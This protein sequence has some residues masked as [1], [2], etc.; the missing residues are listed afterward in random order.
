MRRS[1]N[2]KILLVEDEEIVRE[3][4]CGF[5][6]SEGYEVTEACNGTQAI[7]A[8]K[9]TSFHTLVTDILTPGINGLEILHKARESSPETEVILIS[10]LEKMSHEKA[11]E[12]GAKDFISKS[13]QIGYL[14]KKII[15]T[16]E[17]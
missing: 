3:A 16:I 2:K 9:N 13:C 11:L 7:K 1:K 17:R 6:Q 15:E 4:L 14:V 5:L 12:L 8:L 10:G